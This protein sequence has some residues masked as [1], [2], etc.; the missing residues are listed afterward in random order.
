M[1]FKLPQQ[2]GT[3]KLSSVIQLIL[4]LVLF[5]TVYLLLRRV[6]HSLPLRILILIGDYFIVSLFTYTVIRPLM[7]KLEAA[8]RNRK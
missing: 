2:D 7:M 1:A 5:L 6:V 3:A 4:F 8:L